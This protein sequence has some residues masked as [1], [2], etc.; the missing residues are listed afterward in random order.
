MKKKQPA[1][2]FREQMAESMAELKGIMVRGECEI[3]ED[4]D[5]VGRIFA[6]LAEERDPNDPRPA[7]A[8][9]AQPKRVGLKVVPY[10]TFTWD[11]SKLGGRY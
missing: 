1:Q 9:K 11:H 8:A 10:K 4:P 7:G 2:T 6:W 3:I 5:E